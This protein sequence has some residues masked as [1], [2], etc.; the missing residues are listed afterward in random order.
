MNENGILTFLDAYMH[1]IGMRIYIPLGCAYA[2][3]TDV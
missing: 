3:H 1:P 2:S